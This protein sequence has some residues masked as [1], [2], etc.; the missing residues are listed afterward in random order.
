MAEV[1]YNETVILPFLE[2]KCK[3]LLAQNL[4]LEAR[5]LA[6]LEKSAAL[7]KDID[8]LKAKVEIKKK[9]TKD[10]SLDGETY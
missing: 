3:E 1:N 5:L 4:V 9:K 2:R 7:Q 6:E 10:I 8:N